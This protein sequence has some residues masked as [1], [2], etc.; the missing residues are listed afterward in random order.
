MKAI[1]LGAGQG[2]R[3]RPL[4]D[5][6]PKCMVEVDGAPLLDWQLYALRAAG[7]D[8]VTVVRG[9]CR[10]AISGDGL[11]FVD[12]HR[13]AET[14]M[15]QSLRCAADHLHGDVIVAYTDL[16][17]RP[18]VIQRARQSTA[19]IGV[20]VD[21]EWRALWER[22]MDDPL[23][24]AETLR[25]DG[26]GRLL[27]IGRRP[28]SFDEIEAQYLGIV[29]L[30]PAGCDVLRETFARAAEADATGRTVF[31]SE[32]TLDQAYFTDLL[33]GLIADG[34]VVKTVPIHGGWTE[35]DSH[36]DLRVA[37]AIVREQN[38]THPAAM[39]ETVGA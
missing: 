12:N 13:F 34:Y 35:V 5:D 4:T 38:W 19:D 23:A 29:R 24:D 6:R 1:L 11:R 9:W 21:M 18:E 17:Y 30:S 8:D 10:T 37:E 27:E 3:L 26:K 39:T 36:D 22:R 28:K 31:G 20:V 33:D 32:R 14:N 25:T 15:V 16:L 7:I 2:T